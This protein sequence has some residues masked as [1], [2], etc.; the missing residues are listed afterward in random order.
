M[1]IRLAFE[2]CLHGRPFTRS[3]TP[4]LLRQQFPVPAREASAGPV[5]SAVRI[6][7]WGG[8][9]C[10]DALMSVSGEPQVRPSFT[11]ASLHT[12]FT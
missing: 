11:G 4:P 6:K 3:P 7:I 5:G 12:Q 9:V 8:I 1:Q 10:H 2:K